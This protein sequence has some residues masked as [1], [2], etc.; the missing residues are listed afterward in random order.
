MHY[1]FGCNITKCDQG[2]KIPLQRHTLGHKLHLTQDPEAGNVTVNSDLL[3]F[4]QMIGIESKSTFGYCSARTPLITERWTKWTTMYY[5][6]LHKL[7]M[8][9]YCKLKY[10]TFMWKMSLCSPSKALGLHYL[11]WC[12]MYSKSFY[13]ENSK[14]TWD[15]TGKSCRSPSV[16]LSVSCWCKRWRHLLT[17]S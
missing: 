9:N 16:C 14:C 17:L 3:G 5:V 12:D 1:S 2:V 10:N 8:S 4:I 6:F 13:E 15:T 11:L 7:N